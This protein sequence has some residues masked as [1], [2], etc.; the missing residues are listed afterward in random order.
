MKETIVTANAEALKRINEAQ[1]TLV[2]IRF[3]HEVFEDFDKS[4]ILH[5]G[6]PI[7]WDSMCGPLK[8]A[9]IGAIRYEG[10]ADSEEEAAN[11]AAGGRIRFMPNHHMGAVGPM[12]GMT[13]Y[14]MPLFVVKNE[15]Y[16]NYSYCT[17]NEGLGKVMRFGANDDEVISRLKWLQTVLAPALKQAVFRAGGI[18]LKVIAAQALTM[19][20]EMH[21]RNV[22][23]SSLFVRAIM[24]HLVDVV[25][26]KGDL[27]DI[28]RF[29]AG[30]DQ[31]FLNL[32]MAMGKA[33]ADPAYD[34]PH[35]TMVTAMARNGT[36]FGIRV[37]CTG[38]RWFE[39]P[40]EMP[41][42][43]YFPGYSAE[44]ANPDMGDSTI[45]E[46]MG[47]GGFCMGT[48][49]AVVRFVGAGTPQDALNY[50]REMGQI[51]VGK[52]GSY[53]L[54]NLNFEGTPTGIDVLK[55]VEKGITPV[56]NTGIAHKQPGIGQVGAGIVRA[57]L[58]CFE[59]GLVG[60]GEMLE[61]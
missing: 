16:G 39:A 56:I 35:S 3:A 21:Q 20:D 36:N 24:P 61:K 6:P 28:T 22:A 54:P 43:L 25:D 33:T 9:V 19:G 2:D 15:T 40:V 49:P 10:L 51:T 50:T 60:I 18:N 31:F 26:H 53:I 32:A 7:D 46:T 30:N 23:A 58:A 8:G 27:A 4:T 38:D 17:I 47:L 37:S 11:L 34:I 45:V 13:T 52:S 55:V 12:T 59:K 29:I 14:S 1:P 57:P 44:D 42:G 48:A 5:A 41:Q